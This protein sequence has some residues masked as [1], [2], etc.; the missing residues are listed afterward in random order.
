M[1]ILLIQNWDILHGKEDE[2]AINYMSR[3][4]RCT[5]RFDEPRWFRH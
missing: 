1:S 3:I 4:L 2:Y 5:E